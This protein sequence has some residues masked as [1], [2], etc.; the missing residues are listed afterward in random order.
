MSL[1]AEGTLEQLQWIHRYLFQDVYDWAGKIRTIDMSKGGGSVFQP[2]HMFSTG[3]LYAERNL[4][5]DNLLKEL[6][7][8]MFTE[9]LATHFDNFNTLHPFPEGNGRTQRVF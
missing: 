7:K 4:R 1:K 9:R 8:E 5:S 3:V 6:S 2:L